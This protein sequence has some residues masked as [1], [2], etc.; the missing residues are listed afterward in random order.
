MYFLEYVCQRTG[1]GYSFRY[2]KADSIILTGIRLRVLSEDD[3][4]H[5]L[6]RARVEAVDNLMAVR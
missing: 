5:F 2:G 4:F 6:E 1:N 3:D